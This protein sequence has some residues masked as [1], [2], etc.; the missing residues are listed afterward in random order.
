MAYLALKEETIQE[1]QNIAH[2]LRIHAITSTQ[3][4][5]SG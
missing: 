2:R 4:A 5:K 3:A 1:L